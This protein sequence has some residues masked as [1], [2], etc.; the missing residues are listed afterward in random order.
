MPA[1]HDHGAIAH[2]IT[3]LEGGAGDDARGDSGADDLR[4]LL[5]AG[6]ANP[7]RAP[8][9]G[10]TG[11]GGAGKSSLTDELL[12]RFLRQFPERN[13]AVVA[14]DPT[15]RRS[16]GALLGDRI[17]MNSLAAPN[18][19]MRSLATRRQH[20]ATSAVL[21]D[22]I[23]LYRAVGFDLI[24]VETAG[25]GQ[26]DTEIVDVADLSLY[27]M[28]A[29]YGAASQLE[30]IDMLD[31]ADMIVLNKF[32]KRGAED[33]LRDVRKQ[34]RRNH[35]DRMKL[36]DDELPVFPTIASRFND[37]GVN[38]LFLALCAALD[39]ESGDAGRWTQRDGAPLAVAP[40][41]FRLA[42]SAG[43]VG[44]VAL[45]GGDRRS[46]DARSTRAPRRRA[47]AARARAWPLSIAAGAG[48]SGTARA[49][50]RPRRRPAAENLRSTLRAAY[51]RALD[52]IG[53]EAL[54]S[55][56]RLAAARA[57]RHRA[58]V[59]VHRAR[60]R[61][62]RRQLLRI[63]EPHA[64]PEARG[65]EVCTGWGEILRFPAERKSAGR[66]SVH[67]RRVSVPARRRRSHAHV[68]RR[69][70]AGAHQPPLPLPG[71]RATRPRACPP[72]S[73]PPRCTAK[74][75]TCGPTSS[76]APAIPAYPSP[77]STT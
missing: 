21:A 62:A 43:S 49:A 37:P 38:R 16:G 52:D 46:A 75:R 67:R 41:E 71:A 63:A 8:V 68:R 44:A 25:I 60:P 11:T 65:A 45:P 53:A 12:Q 42:R 55:A 69:G 13:V 7:Q 59:F 2:A 77:R 48:R 35:P 36:P 76:G 54:A 64:D 20:L 33:A 34:W 17:R 30:K 73:I 72:P 23:A 70:R 18:V 19:F 47:D 15:R 40:T 50:R 4:R 5:S 29:E 1:V 61:S 28:T 14:V 26:S 6:I 27:V 74:T 3:L 31:F 9:I 57:G 39:E 58:R 32:E 66:L 56:A 51:N 24:V 10:L 22:V